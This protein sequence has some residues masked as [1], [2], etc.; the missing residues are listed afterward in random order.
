MIEYPTHRSISHRIPPN[1]STWQTI[2]LSYQF[3]KQMVDENIEGCFVECGVAAGNN[4]AA[5]CLAGRKGIG[6][7]SFEGIPWAGEHDDIQPGMDSKTENTGLS[8]SRISSHSL[9]DVQANTKLWGIT[10]YELVKG[11]F[12]DTIPEYETGP[13]SVLRLDGDLYESTLVPLLY[14]YPKLSIGG[15]L[16][17]DDWNLSG[18]QKAFFDYFL[19][20]KTQKENIG[21]RINS[22]SIPKEIMFD[23]NVK[24]FQK[25]A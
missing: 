17:I 2:E 18:C 16:I 5:M 25:W 14:L 21:Y 10:N 3:A 13:I 12:Q 23:G 7:D 4:L 20:P 8:S 19:N 11:W 6:F 22:Y 24:Y 15:I 9:D 1:Y